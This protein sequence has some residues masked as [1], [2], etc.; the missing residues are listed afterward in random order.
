[1]ETG[2]GVVLVVDDDADIRSALRDVLGDSGF[3][4][5]EAGTGQK[6][7]DMFAEHDPDV[8]LLDLNLPDVS[9]LDI[10]IEITRNS[11]T[12]VI[13]LSGR[14]GEADRVVGLDLGADDYI[15]KPFSAR[16]LVARLRAAIRRCRPPDEASVLDFDDLVIDEHTHD[17]T[18]DGHLVELTAKEFDLLSFLA[19][20]PR[21]VYDRAQLLEHVW[22]STGSWQDDNTVSEHIHRVR[23][24][25]DPENRTRWIETVRGV[26][27]RFVA[28]G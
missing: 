28:S 8:V 3:L 20:S 15:S 21:R 24:K 17:V 14:T 16:E 9:G 13:V 18:V 12:P 19:R 1:M 4:V 26:G 27:Y 10:L 22:G 11:S 23:R 2:S 7:R 6:A 5:A 25:L